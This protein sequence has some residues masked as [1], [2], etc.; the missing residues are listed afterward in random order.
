MPI[1]PVQKPLE[2]VW[3]RLRRVRPSLPLLDGKLVGPLDSWASLAK[4]RFEY[5][6]DFC[7]DLEPKLLDDAPFG[8]LE[9]GRYTVGAV[10]EF[11][12]A[13]LPVE[14]FTHDFHESA[15]K[16]NSHAKRR[17]R[18]QSVEEVVR[19]QL[20]Q[21]CPFLKDKD[22][23]GQNRK[24]ARSRARSQLSREELIGD[25]GA[26]VAEN[27]DTDDE[28]DD[29]DDDD[30]DDV[31]EDA[32]EDLRLVPPLPPPDGAPPVLLDTARGRGGR[33]SQRRL[34]GW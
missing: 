28:C 33:R 14:V 12:H 18:N 17:P 15:P 8:V 32:P 19:R 31:I 6:D 22:F 1:T 24:T 16:R 30:D 27:V 34:C 4:L 11:P 5:T 23:G 13:Q 2:I 7:M 26:I 20:L 29:D 25:D 21:E 9:D 10:V 3:G